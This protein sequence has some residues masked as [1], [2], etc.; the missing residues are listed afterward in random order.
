MPSRGLWSDFRAH[1][2]SFKEAGTVLFALEVFRTLCLCALLALSIYAT[3]QA[4]SPDTVDVLRKKEHK[5]K[6]HKH[7]SHSVDEYSSLEWGEFGASVFYVSYQYRFDR[8]E[9]TF[10]PTR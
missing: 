1:V 8:L 7:H 5:G 10:R 9:L 2:R 6:K 3:I 4:E